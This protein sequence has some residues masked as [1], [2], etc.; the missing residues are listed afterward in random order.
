MGAFDKFSIAAFDPLHFNPTEFDDLLLIHGSS[1]EL[2]KSQLCPCLRIETRRPAAGCPVCH[3]VG[4]T[5]PVKNRIP[6]VFLDHSRRT[7]AKHNGPGSLADGEL[8]FTLACGIVPGKGDL[9][10]PDDD[11]H[12]VHEVFHRDAQEVTNHALLSRRLRDN[13]FERTSSPTD[14][15]T[16][17]LRGRKAR[18]LYPTVTCLEAVYW[19]DGDR[20]VE[21]HRDI[22]YRL[23]DSEVQWLGETGPAKAQGFTVRYH[24]P[25]AYI[26]FGTG[27]MFRHEH[28]TK[29]PWSGQADRLDHLQRRDDL[30]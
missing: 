29:M 21:A 16:R 28:S 2:R 24:A 10:L 17:P 7:S 11:T 15:F 27:P 4:Y 20:L 23:V 22:D 13:A 25:A 3:G 8:R 19:I 6:T 12:V 30:W 26:I 14:A 1:G 9:L 5:Y 18:L